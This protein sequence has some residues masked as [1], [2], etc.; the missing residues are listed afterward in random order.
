[1]PATTQR[2][3]AWT[4]GDRLSEMG[5]FRALAGST[6][7]LIAVAGLVVVLDSR[8]VLESRYKHSIRNI[9]YMT[10]SMNR[11]NNQW[12]GGASCRQASST[13][14][15]ERGA[16]GAAR[17]HKEKP[18]ERDKQTASGWC[19]R[20]KNNRWV[21]LVAHEQ[22]VL[23]NAVGYFRGTGDRYTDILWTLLMLTPT[24]HPI[25][26]VKIQTFRFQ[27]P[28]TTLSRGA[29]KCSKLRLSRWNTGKML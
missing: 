24:A 1:V 25:P 3:R 2:D 12:L 21:A 27:P 26:I 23:K 20:R 4:R 11:G 6:Q 29:S 10:D 14:G 19:T 17:T 15:A 8:L 9:A 28:S 13:D 7:A 22:C 18:T 16:L 5:C